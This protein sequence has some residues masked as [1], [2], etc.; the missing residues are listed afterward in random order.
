MLGNIKFGFMG[1]FEV[2]DGGVVVE[3]IV[4]LVSKNRV[5]LGM[6][7]VAIVA[8]SSSA[9]HIQVSKKGSFPKIPGWL[10]RLG[11]MT[12]LGPPWSNGI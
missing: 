8:L 11:R 4:P 3:V 6:W 9:S 10:E 2:V 1:P 5:G 7:D 12:G